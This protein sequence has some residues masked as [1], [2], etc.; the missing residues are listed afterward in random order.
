LRDLSNSVILSSMCRGAGG[1][2]QA[3]FFMY[4][5]FSYELFSVVPLACKKYLVLIVLAICSI[6]L[7]MS[8]VILLD[9][10]QNFKFRP[11]SSFVPAGSFCVLQRLWNAKFLGCSQSCEGVGHNADL[12]F[13]EMD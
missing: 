10:R 12:K 2:F 13:L 4:I 9:E 6:V 5:C 8:L 11:N 7:W 3:A 1:G